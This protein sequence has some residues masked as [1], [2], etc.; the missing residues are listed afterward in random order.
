MLKH[1]H[2]LRF[3]DQILL[4][5]ALPSIA[6]LVSLLSMWPLG[7]AATAAIGSLTP[8]LAIV[9]VVNVGAFLLTLLCTV[10]MA[11]IVRKSFI[12][13]LNGLVNIA[14]TY[15]KSAGSNFSAS[16]EET[17]AKLGNDP[18]FDRDEIGV[19][20]QRFLRTTTE[21]SQRQ[22]DSTGLLNRVGKALQSA[23]VGLWELDVKAD[24][25]SFDC[26]YADTLRTVAPKQS[27]SLQETDWPLHPED[28]AEFK[29]RLREFLTGEA[30][31]FEFDHLI[32]SESGGFCRV[33]GFGRATAFDAEGRPTQ[34]S[35]TFRMI[36]ETR[37]AHDQLR[38]LNKRL[39]AEKGSFEPVVEQAGSVLASV[40][41]TA[42]HR[43]E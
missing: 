20:T 26:Q 19:L 38:S 35:G 28:R 31:Q 43:R 5:A 10:A 29:A 36:V 14:E 24:S 22:L 30:P 21:I 1:V 7:N 25:L 23:Q 37:S 13:R 3:R 32:R 34:A 8:T 40:D 33:E 9:S 17:K 16:M 6:V 2:R 41:Q 15:S 39:I 11:V 18:W 4:A 27:Y 12:A 42:S